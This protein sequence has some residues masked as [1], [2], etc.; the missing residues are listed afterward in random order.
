MQAITSHWH[1]GRGVRV[2]AL[3]LLAAS[4]GCQAVHP[5]VRTNTQEMEDWIQLVMPVRIKVLKW[6]KPVSIENDG[7]ADCLEVIL[8]AYDS[9]NDETKVVGDFQF[10]LESRRMS[11]HIGQRIGFWPLAVNSAE[12]MRAYLD[13]PSRF[14]RFPLRLPNPPLAAGHYQ[15]NV[16]LELPTG[17]VLLDTY[18]FDY[19]GTSAPALRE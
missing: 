12:T 4:L 10:E 9:F 14:Y 1:I 6:T 13:H 15:L 5:S 8:A 17:A 19:E 16:R 18:E 2:A 11:E 3:L 7:K